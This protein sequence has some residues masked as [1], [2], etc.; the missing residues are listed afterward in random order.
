[1]FHR[2]KRKQSLIAGYVI[3]CSSSIQEPLE[4][5]GTPG[6]GRSK[7]DKSNP[8]LVS[9]FNSVLQPSDEDSYKSS[10]AK[11]FDF[12]CFQTAGYF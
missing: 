6:P 11:R 9:I 7:Q 5:L 10:N 2:A 4:I 12:S 1:M 8:G 3:V